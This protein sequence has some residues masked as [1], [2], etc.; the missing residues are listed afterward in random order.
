MSL[1]RRG[2][3]ELLAELASMPD[4]LEERFR[5]LEA[6]RAAR[7]PDRDLFAPVEHCW[8]LADLEVEGFGERIRRL[9]EELEPQL[10]DFDGGRLAE[11]RRYRS[12]P[13][14]DG[15]AAFRSARRANLS[16]LRALTAE[17]WL[18]GGTQEGVGRLSLC[19]LPAM[20]AEHDAAHREEIE[21]WRAT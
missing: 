20:M 2:Q 4:L 6:E 13:L 7:R 9:A 8:H 10:P 17:Q 18:R 15:I 19:D 21:T 3:E 14:A 11:E 5:G 16:R 12:R 1:D